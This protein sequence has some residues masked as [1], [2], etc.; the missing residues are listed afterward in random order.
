MKQVEHWWLSW[1]L[2]CLLLVVGVLITMAEPV[3]S[4][5]TE[6][7]ARYYCSQYSHVDTEN[8]LS[9][10]NATISSLH[11][12]LSISRFAT[13]R[14][15]SNGVS[16]W[17]LAWCRG[18]VSIPDCL[19]CFNYAV[20]QLKSCGT[21]NGGHGFY[22]DC[23]V[24]Y[25]NYNFFTDFNSP[26]TLLCVNKT[27]AK[28]T[29]FRITA[30]RLILD[31]QIAAPRTS[32]L[33]AVST[34]KEADGN[35]TV[36]AI[37]QCHLNLNDSSCLRCLKLKSKSLYDCLPRTSGWAFDYGCFIRYSRTPF[38][39]QNQTTDIASLLSDGEPSTLLEIM[40]SHFVL[41]QGNFGNLYF[42]GDS[43]AKKS[44]IIGGVVGGVEVHKAWNLYESGT[45]LNLMDENLDPREYAAEHAVEIIEIALMCTQHP[46]ARPAMS[47]VVMLLSEKSLQ[48]RQSVKSTIMEDELE[49]EVATMEPLASYATASTSQLSGS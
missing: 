10:L 1:Q 3:S 47:E 8:F 19:D 30:E 43:Y 5:S 14:T 31:L 26:E 48:E 45:H 38:F 33:Y 20:A 49:I 15:L 9:N 28:P 6:R 37:A 13:A 7:I 40:I 41:N 22:N 32:E 2:L 18:Y 27:S 34:R 44:S 29:E 12:Q 23:D 21:V 35:A 17:G 36:Y 4:Q 11:R 25:E 39:G 46:S 42:T 24:R 16:V